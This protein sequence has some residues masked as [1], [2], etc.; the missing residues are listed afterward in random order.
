MPALDGLR[1]LAVAAVLAYHADLPWARAGFL[2]VDVFFV[3]SGFLITSLL[4]SEWRRTGRLR[5][6]A[7]YRRRALRLL[8]ALFFLL[9]VMAVA[10]P[11]LA[12]D[13]LGRLRGDLIGALSYVSNWTLIYQHQSY[14]AAIGRPPVLQ[15]L[16]SLAVE[17]QFYLLWPALLAIGL[18]S[19]K[20]Q[21]IK[22][23]LCCI[24][25]SGALM[26]LI[27]AQ[28]TDLSRTYYGTDT[29]LGT[30]LV[31]A[32]LALLWVP[33]AR[34]GKLRPIWRLAMDLGGLAALGGL[35]WC[36]SH[37]TEF[38]AF[39]Y[40]G[41]FTLVALLAGVAVAFTANPGFVIRA[42]LGSRPFVWLGQRSYSIYLWHWPVFILTRPHSDIPLSGYPLLAIRLAATLALACLS[43][44]LVER[45]VRSGAL[46]RAWALLREGIARRSLRPAALAG[47]A[48]PLLVALP[49]A[50][51]IGGFGHWPGAAPGGDHGHVSVS[52]VSSQKLF[53]P[54]EVAD[55]GAPPPDPAQPANPP[56]P[57]A[58]AQP[59]PAPAPPRPHRFAVNAIGDAGML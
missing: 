20:S 30:I 13:Q 22:S 44:G 53:G 18:R 21:L 1:A 33:I 15:H 54:L 38:D 2:G 48:S 6:F 26:A 46:G 56:D 42:V 41:G 4:Y 8:P 17:E 28:G 32:L 59:A 3:I 36:I 35:G 58:A 50:A 11:V 57:A 12:P 43:Y 31:G 37:L 34:R 47:V 27:Y 23:T 19:S 14:F 9:A 45:P 39:L 40:K 10:L 52:S 51:A 16:W 7:F 49:L 24:G 29:R 25:V 5:I 55:A